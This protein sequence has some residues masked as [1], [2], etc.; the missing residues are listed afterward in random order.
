MCSLCN[1]GMLTRRSSHSTL[2]R[3]LSSVLCP[4]SIAPTGHCFVIEEGGEQGNAF[5]QNL[6]MLTRS[7]SRKIPL[8]PSTPSVSEE[9]DDQP[10]TFWISNMGNTYQGNVAAGSEDSG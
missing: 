5:I 7:V 4:P 3:P 10:S 6:G 9:T 1:L 2:L 8:S